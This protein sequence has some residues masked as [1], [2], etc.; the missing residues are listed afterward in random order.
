MRNS[1]TSISIFGFNRPIHLE[2]TL[3]TLSNLNVKNEKIFIFVDGPR[4]SEDIPYVEETLIVAEK[5]KQKFEAI[6]NEV[7]IVNS[8]KN[9]GLAKS[10][11]RGIN[12]VF[13]NTNSQRIIVLEDDCR[14]SKEFLTYM[15]N[16]FD[17]YEEYNKFSD[18][19]VMHISG[20]G[21]PLNYY[22]KN[23]T[24][25]LNYLNSYPCSWGWGTWKEFWI[26]CKFND[27]KYY[28]EILNNNHLKNQFNNDGSAFSEFLDLYRQGKVN[29]WLIQWYAYIFKN[30]GLCSW[31]ILSS[32]DNSGFD[33]TGNHKV[34]FDRFNQTE[35]YIETLNKKM[36]GQPLRFTNEFYN[37]EIQK[38]FKRYFISSKDKIKIN[39]LS[40]FLMKKLRR[41]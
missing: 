15:N 35:K 41:Y 6:D 25:E 3:S 30:S 22:L 21:L 36:K 38:E 5:Y 7:E 34:K 23:N 4:N 33:G 40:Y 31:K 12:H 32:I 37:I 26:E 24:H 10:I 39:I 1:N 16:A 2:N 19:K 8:K 13:E 18:Q 20:F 29:S 9:I 14:P 27:S 11:I 28:E 17:Y